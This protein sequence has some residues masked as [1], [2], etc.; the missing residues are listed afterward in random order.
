MDAATTVLVRP[1]P[2]DLFQDS[3]ARA[4]ETKA[5]EYHES[6]GDAWGADR[7]LRA[8]ENLAGYVRGLPLADARFRLLLQVSAD[9]DN[10]QLVGES[11][12]FVQKLGLDNPQPD[13]LS[14]SFNEFV[15]SCGIVPAPAKGESQIVQRLQAQQAEDH[16]AAAQREA[17]LQAEIDK[18][19]R[20][21]AENSQ[22]LSD[23]RGRVNALG[24]DQVETLSRRVATLEGERDQAERRA[25][26]AENKT[27]RRARKKV[28]V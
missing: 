20:A 22:E 27:A 13:D 11:P 10:F 16:L 4:I 14:A 19:D 8:C 18:R 28:A 9:S 6:I 15:V 25:A 7:S 12:E 17:E 21:L 24:G 2:T 1:H 5:R 23:L 26:A 3:V